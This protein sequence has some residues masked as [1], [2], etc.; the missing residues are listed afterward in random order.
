MMKGRNA[1]EEKQKT[2]KG[3]APDSQ[4]NTI[5]SD[6]ESPPFPPARYK[7]D[8]DSYDGFEAAGKEEKLNAPDGRPGSLGFTYKHHRENKAEYEKTSSDEKRIIDD[9]AF[10][11]DSDDKRIEDDRSIEMEELDDDGSTFLRPGAVAIRGIAALRSPGDMA[12]AISSQVYAAR[13]SST[14]TTVAVPVPDE[15]PMRLMNGTNGKEDQEK[16][17]KS[18]T[19]DG[20]VTVEED[21]LEASDEPSGSFVFAHKQG[22]ERQ[23]R[24]GRPVSN[25]NVVDGGL[26]AH[27]GGRAERQSKNG[28]TVSNDNLEDSTDDTSAFLRPGAIAVPGIAASTLASQ[29][30][31]DDFSV[32]VV[33]TVSSQV[34]TRSPTIGQDSLS[35]IAVAVPD[36]DE[37][38]NRFQE[39]EFAKQTLEQRQ[40]ML[41][42][43]LAENQRKRPGTVSGVA[44]EMVDNGE[45]GERSRGNRR[46]YLS[47]LVGIVILVS[48]TIGVVLVKRRDGTTSLPGGSKPSSPS[49]GPISPTVAPEISN[50]VDRLTIEYPGLD[51]ESMFAEGTP[52]NCAIN[53]LAF[54]DD[55]TGEAIADDLPSQR[56]GER[57]AL[58]V[59]FFA[60]TGT[61]CNNVASSLLPAECELGPAE[62]DFTPGDVDGVDVS[63]N[64]DGFI[65]TL[66]L[67]EYIQT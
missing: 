26:F 42:E 51:M 39:L 14:T 19:V 6:C 30:H 66:D 65:I 32:A 15:D 18:S 40:Q 33:S 55:W 16:G 50:L 37:M 46:F 21:K 9:I 63:C 29:D 2:K 20:E 27:K 13:P 25:D 57:Y 11:I 17:E 56:I 5:P 52:Q 59:M 3:T 36:E 53:W 43:T 31:I 44:V 60:T 49:E 10:K 34:F 4:S 61:G 22:R 54:E 64:E 24:K 67:G 12:S 1:Q 8:K 7:D 35:P 62:E 41:D 23:S 48:I 28:G 45:G 58:A 47:F 38:P